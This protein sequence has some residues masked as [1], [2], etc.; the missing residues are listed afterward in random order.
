MNFAENELVDVYFGRMLKKTVFYYL[1][2][3]NKNILIDVF[4]VLALYM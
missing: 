2:C 1:L 4:Q 3:T